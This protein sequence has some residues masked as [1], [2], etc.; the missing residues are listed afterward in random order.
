[1]STNKLTA[2]LIEKKFITDDLIVIKIKPNSSFVYRPGQYCTVGVN[3]TERPYSIVSA[4]HEE[5][6]EL[7]VELVPDGTLTPNFWKV[8]SGDIINIRPRAKGIFTLENNYD[9]HFMI[10]TVTGIAPIL[11]MIRDSL[12]HGLN[13]HKF[14]I[15]HGASFEKELAYR[16]ELENLSSIHDNIFYTPTVSRPYDPE[17]KGW[18]GETGRANNIFYKY[19]DKFSLSHENTLIY[20]CG[21]PGMVDDVEAQARGKGFRVKVEKYWSN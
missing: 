2:I 20:A 11:S 21:H 13:S 6:I 15:I 10:A 14:Y 19:I 16:S 8:N 18:E 12:H 3:G 4:P 5:Y 9:N 1:M 17:N 7:F